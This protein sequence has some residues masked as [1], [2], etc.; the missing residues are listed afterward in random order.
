MMSSTHNYYMKSRGQLVDII[1]EREKIIEKL[2]T[3]IKESEELIEALQAACAGRL[4]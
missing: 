1:I 2:K 4:G 3:E